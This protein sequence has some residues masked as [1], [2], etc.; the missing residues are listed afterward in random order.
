MELGSY[1]KHNTSASLQPTR[2]LRG[3]ASL[4]SRQRRLCG[5]QR[6]NITGKELDAETGLYYYG[7]RY[8]D[9]KTGRWI[10][11]VFNYVNLHVYHYAGNNPVRYV[12]PNGRTPGNPFD[13]ADEAAI[14]VLNY[15]NPISFDS[16]NFSD[17]T[18]YLGTPSGNF[19]KYNP[20]SGEPPIRIK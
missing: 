8:L 15:I 12:D 3:T 11:G 9:P 5:R 4:A 19:L 18:G 17:Y 10:S 14:D 20:W 16:D 13:T 7:A 6:R 2:K 1:H